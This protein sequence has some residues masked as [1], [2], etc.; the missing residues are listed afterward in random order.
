[1]ACVL[2]KI[3]ASR[4]AVA[5]RRDGFTDGRLPQLYSVMRVSASCAAARLREINRRETLPP[6]S[7]WRHRAA[8][9][10]AFLL[11]AKMALALLRPAGASASMAVK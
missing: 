8:S 5:L 9:E 4:I 3:A 2:A 6:R 10:E 11:C 1:M 7:A